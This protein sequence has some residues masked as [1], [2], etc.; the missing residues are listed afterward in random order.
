[1]KSL[2]EEFKIG[3]ARLFQMLR[4]A[5]DP[6]VKSAQPDIITGRKWNAKY[7]VE[8]AKSFHKMKEVINWES[9]TWPSPTT[10]VVK[11]D[12]KE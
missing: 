5:V 2:V 3:K 12:H 4:D 1:M 11:R 7:A 6:L 10:V 8:T 9:R